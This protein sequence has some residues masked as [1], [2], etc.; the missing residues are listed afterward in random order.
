MSV[1]SFP[2]TLS[3]LQAIA[4]SRL[5]LARHDRYQGEE[6]GL[7]LDVFA[8]EDQKLLGR[9]Y[10]TL[11]RLFHALKPCQHSLADS[12]QVLRE[13]VST[14]E[15]QNLSG[16]VS[17]FGH[18]TAYKSAET[19]RVVH[20]LRGGAFQALSFRLQLFALDPEVASGIPNCYFLVRDHLKIMRNCVEDLD[21]ERFHQDSLSLAHDAQLLVEKWSHADFHSVKKRV[22]VDLECHYEGTLCESCLEFS[23]L[24]RIIYNLMNNAARHTSDGHVYFYVL[25]VPEPEEANVRFVVVNAITE[26]HREILLEK[27]GDDLG[28]I[29]RGGFTTDGHGFGTRICADFCAHAYGIFDFTKAKKGG[30]FGAQLIG[31]YFVAWFHWPK[32]GR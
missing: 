21:P 5:R 9:I 7:N 6:E 15:Y 13:F 28:E 30:Y 27:F 10:E 11:L 4:P 18:S 25:P 24:D 1:S 12:R 29:F 19:D 8:P 20:D 31:D 3:E 22:L 14:A 26:E 16:E 17:R 2:L 23:S 32:V